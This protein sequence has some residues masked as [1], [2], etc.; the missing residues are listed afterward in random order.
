ML[1]RTPT[2]QELADALLAEDPSL[3]TD[4]LVAALA[5]LGV[6]VARKTAGNY[7]WAFCRF[8]PGLWIVEECRRTNEASKRWKKENPDRVAELN[9]RWQKENPERAAENDRRWKK[10]NLA[11]YLWLQA[12]GRAR[13][14]G[15]PFGLTLGHVE[16]LVEPMICA[17]SGLPLVWDGPSPGH[18]APWAPSPDKIDPAQFYVDGNV[19]IVANMFNNARGDGPDEDVLRVARALMLGVGRVDGGPTPPAA[20]AR[21]LKA[22]RGS[23]RRRGEPFPLTREDVLE[24]LPTFNCSVTGLPLEWNGDRHVGQ[25]PFGLSLDRLGLTERNLYERGNFRPTCWLYNRM[26]GTWTDD[27][28]RR[29]CRALVERE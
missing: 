19:R 15:E 22:A 9:R 21:V 11:R 4:G 13:R 3:T 24:T 10:E 16:E 25:G 28:C 2:A 7:R 29:L 6:R 5:A 26:K 8:G 27:D 1:Q 23:A 17:V 20:V 18:G 14:R 12:R